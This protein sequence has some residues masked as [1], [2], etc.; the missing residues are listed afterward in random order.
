MKYVRIFLKILL[1]LIALILLF[2]V[3]NIVPVDNTPYQQTDFYKETGNRLAALTRPAPAQAPIQAGWARENLTPSFTTPTGGY[4]ARRGKQWTEVHDSVYVKAVVLDNGSSRVALVALDLLITPPTVAEALKKRLPEIGF[5]WENVFT[6]A[7]HSH[8]TIG[9]WAPGLVGGL[10]AGEYDERVVP[11]ITDRILKAIDRA[12]KQLAPVTIGYTQADGKSLVYNRLLENGPVFGDIQLLKLQKASGESAV[13][14]TYGG[15]ATVID[16]KQYQYL[17]RDYPGALVDKLEQETG[18]FTLF[19][20]GAVGSTGPKID[21]PDRLAAMTQYADSLSRRIVPALKSLKPVA[22]SS[23]GM[24]TLPL[25]LRDPH[26]RISDGLRVRPWIFHAVYGDYPSELKALRIGKT[27]FVGTPCDFSGMLVPALQ[28]VARQKALNLV[29]TSFNG[30]YIGYITPDQYYHL[31]RY[32][33]NDM[34]WFGPQNGDY[35]VEMM[36]GLIRKF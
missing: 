30:G 13:V 10:I 5:R 2:A 8:N 33:T 23:L 29:V 27:V 19:L 9:A 11:L 28:P 7:I 15:H 31:G 26:V 25:T 6:G 21:G 22:D 24:L 35:F 12:Q 34:N 36:S 32:E 3:A 20:A 1:G 18:S 16:M 4:G 17:S 14:C